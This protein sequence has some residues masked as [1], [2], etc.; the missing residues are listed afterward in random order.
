MPTWIATSGALRLLQ[1]RGSIDAE[2]R[3]PD[4]LVHVAEIR[5][6]LVDQLVE[7]VEAHRADVGR[8]D[9]GLH[10]AEAPERRRIAREHTERRDARCERMAHGARE[11]RVLQ[12][13]LDDL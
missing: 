1:L 7:S 4:L 10:A 12:E 5:L 13:E 6:H 8:G 11:L 2:P 3:R 9:A